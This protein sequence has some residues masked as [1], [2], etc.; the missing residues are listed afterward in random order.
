MVSD[1]ERGAVTPSAPNW[2]KMAELV[3]YQV[4]VDCYERI[5]LPMEAV[6]ILR[7]AWSKEM[8][9]AKKLLSDFGVVTEPV[10]EGLADAPLGGE[11][12]SLKGP[13][14]SVEEVYARNAPASK[15]KRA[16]RRK[17]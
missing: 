11:P 16:R 9:V 10:T 12:A 4:K 8:P 5:G 15:T 14:K 6:R 2:I 3:D 7:E 13:S 17:K 1:W